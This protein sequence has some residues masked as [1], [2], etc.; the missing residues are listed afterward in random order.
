MELERIR[1][2]GPDSFS[3]LPRHI[4]LGRISF[5]EAL[6]SQ[7]EAIA[8]LQKGGFASSII[9]SLEHD[10]VIT[11]GRS[12][13]QANLLLP[14]HE[15]LARGIELRRIDRGGDVTWHG[16]GQVVVY[17][18]LR[19][20]DWGLKPGEYVRLLEETMILTCRD[21]GVEAFRRQRFPGCWTQAGKIGAV[22]TSVKAGGITKHGLAFNVCNDLTPFSLIIPCGIQNCLVTRLVDLVVTEVDQTDVENRL[23]SHLLALLLSRAKI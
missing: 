21:F 9:F 1:G 6:H 12:A 14:E 22:G 15:Y 11:C 13:K 3:A 5:D 19:L 2:V 16:P 10:P 23:V 17:P 18:V 7:E 4:R 8:R 20:G